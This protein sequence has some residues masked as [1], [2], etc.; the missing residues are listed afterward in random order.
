MPKVRRARLPDAL[1]QHL[2]TRARERQIPRSDVVAFAAWLDTD[3]EV[4]AGEWFKRF[5]GLI[6]CGES[7]LVKTFLG[8]GQVLHGQEVP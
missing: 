1:F 8:P 3:P 7:E 4:P 2:L 6:V 5:P